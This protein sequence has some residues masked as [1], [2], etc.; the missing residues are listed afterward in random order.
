[1]LAFVHHQAKQTLYLTQW[2][3]GIL[4]AYVDDVPQQVHGQ[5]TTFELFHVGTRTETQVVRFVQQ[6]THLLTNCDTQVCQAG[7]GA[8]GLSASC[9]P[10][11]IYLH[12][13]FKFQSLWQLRVYTSSPQRT[14]GGVT[15]LLP[16]SGFQGSGFPGKLPSPRAIPHPLRCFL[17]EKCRTCGVHE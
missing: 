14:S 10:T 11:G 4:C 13:S 17:N 6:H 16:P 8:L 12:V 7:R 9:L 2:L 1:M 5:R 15:S 3:P